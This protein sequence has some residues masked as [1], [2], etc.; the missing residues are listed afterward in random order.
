MR[1]RGYFT[2]SGFV[3]YVGSKQILFADE[4]EYDDYLR[5]LE[6]SESKE[7]SAS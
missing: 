3:G 7:E 1:R 2:H 5:E 4:S 6:Q